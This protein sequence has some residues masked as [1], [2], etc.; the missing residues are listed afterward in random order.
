MSV[1]VCLRSKGQRV[2]TLSISEAEYVAI[3]EAVNE[4]KFIDSFLKEIGIEIELLIKFK[5]SLK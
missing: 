3:S 5:I 1:P 2:V 4:V